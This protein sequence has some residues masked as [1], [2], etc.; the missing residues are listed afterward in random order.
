[1][2]NKYSANY[3]W[4][5]YIKTSTDLLYE[6]HPPDVGEM[7]TFFINKVI[8]NLKGSSIV[9]LIKVFVD[10]NDKEDKEPPENVENIEINQTSNCSSLKIRWNNPGNKDFKGVILARK[11]SLISWSPKDGCEY[12]PGKVKNTDIIIIYNGNKNNY[13]D[14]NIE[15]DSYYFFKIFSYDNKFNYS[16]GVQKYLKTNISMPEGEINANYD[17]EKDKFNIHF[18][19]NEYTEKIDLSYS[20]GSDNTFKTIKSYEVGLSKDFTKSISIENSLRNN[21]IC[22]IAEVINNLNQR[23]FTDK[24]CLPY[25]VP[26]SIY[27]E[28]PNPPDLREM[29]KTYNYNNIELSWKKVLDKNNYQNATYYI[30]RYSDNNLFKNYKDEKV[31]NPDETSKYS[32]VTHTINN[33]DDNKI[34]YFKVIAFNDLCEDQEDKWLANATNWSKTIYAIINLP[35]EPEFVND[36]FRPVNGEI[37]VSKTPALE[38]KVNDNDNEDIDYCVLIS[39]NKSNFE[40]LMCFHQ[41]YQNKSELDFN[42]DY[43]PL[44]PYT[45]YY[46]KVRARDRELKLKNSYKESEVFEFTTIKS[47]PDLSIT[48]IDYNPDD[49]KPDKEVLFKLTVKNIGSEKSNNKQCIKANYKKNNN[50]SPFRIY[51]GCMKEYLNVNESEIVDFTVKFQ[52]SIIDL[53]GDIYDNILISGDSEIKF[54]FLFK[55]DQDLDLSNNSLIKKINY[56]NKGKPELKY[57]FLD[58]SYGERM[59]ESSNDKFWGCP[60]CPIKISAEA[61][62][63]I[64]II[65]GTIEVQYESTEP[66][67]IFDKS[68]NKS[69]MN[70]QHDY[71][72]GNI[73]KTTIVRFIVSFKDDNNLITKKESPYFK[74]YPNNMDFKVELEQDEFVANEKI[75]YQIT[76]NHSNNIYKAEVFL[77]DEF[78]IYSGY[79]QNGITF[80]LKL[81]YTITNKYLVSPNCYLKATLI[82]E[83]NNKKEYKSKTFS[84]KPDTKLPAPFLELSQIYNKQEEIP[85]NAVRCGYGALTIQ[86]KKLLY[87]NIDNANKVHA[88]I[89][90]RCEYCVNDQ[91]GYNEDY[92]FY[93]NDY[94]YILYDPYSKEVVNEVKMIEQDYELVAFNLSDNI[95]YAIFES[96]NQELY[97]TYINRNKFVDLKILEN[98]NMPILKNAEK[99]SEFDESSS[100][101]SDPARY[102]L[103]DRTI[104][105]L[106]ISY[107]NEVDTYNFDQG[108]IGKRQEIR[109][110]KNFNIRNN[111][112]KPTTVNNK[113]KIYACD[114]PNSKLVELDT[115]SNIIKTFKIPYNIGSSGEEVQKTSIA[116]YDGNLFIFGNGRFYI[117]EN[118]VIIDKGPISFYDEYYEKNEDISSKWSQIKYTKSIITEN[119]IYLI[120]G[121]SV[122][123]ISSILMFNSSNYSFTKKIY[124]V[125]YKKIS[126]SPYCD[127]LYIG[128]D[129]VLIA[130][131]KDYAD[132]DYSGAIHKYYS[133]LNI[134]D[135]K[136]GDIAYL[137]ELP[138]KSKDYISLLKQDNNIFLIGKNE[139]LHKTEIF[140]L[141]IGNI[142]NEAKLVKN[143]SLQQ[144]NGNLYAIWNY[145]TP[146]NGSLING[147]YAYKQYRRNIIQQ[148]SPYSNDKKIF[149]NEY[150]SWITI[151]GQ[152]HVM[153]PK[154]QIFTINHNL[155]ANTEYNIGNGEYSNKFEFKYFDNSKIIGG[156]SIDRKLKLVEKDYNDIDIDCNIYEPEIAAFDSCVIAAGK[157]DNNFTV[158]KYDL[159]TR[160]YF[161]VTV[162][163]D[164][165]NKAF[166]KVDINKNKW[167]VLGWDIFVTVADFSKDVI[168]PEVK[169]IPISDEISPGNNII[170]NWTAV[171]NQDKLKYF[172]II[173]KENTIEKKKEII[174]DITINEFKY[175][176]PENSTGKISFS[177]TA[178]DIDGNH[179]KDVIEH[180]IINPVILKALQINKTQAFIGENVTF[181]W[182]ADNVKPDTIY[183]AYIQKNDGQWDELFVETENT[184]KIVS[185]DKPGS[186]KFKLV[187]ENAILIY[188]ETIAI[189]DYNIKFESFL[190][191]TSTIYS[192]ANPSIPLTWIMK[193][194][195]TL[196]D[197]CY[198]YIKTNKET[199]FKLIKEISH[200]DNNTFS[201]LYN[202]QDNISSFNWKV[203]AVYHGFEYTSN[204]INVQ[205]DELNSP[206]IKNL[207]L[208]NAYTSEPAI[209]VIFDLLPNI[210]DYIILKKS[211]D[212][213]FI[214]VNRTQ[215]GNYLDKNISYNQS[216]TYG[217]KSIKNDVI[218]SMGNIKQV[219][220]EIIPIKRINVLSEQ[221]KTFDS[222]EIVINYYPEPEQCFEY[223]EINVYSE[224]ESVAFTRTK[225]KNR[226]ITLT[227]LLYSHNYYANIYPLDFEGNR[228]T[229]TPE[230]YN[231]TTGF[232]DRVITEIPIIDIKSVTPESVLLQWKAIKNADKYIIYRRVEFNDIMI[233]QD[234]TANL[235]YADYNDIIPGI[236]YYYKLEAAKTDTASNQFSLPV[237]VLIPHNKYSIEDVIKAFQVL[238]ENSNIVYTLLDIN[239]D[240]TNDIDDVIILLNMLTTIETN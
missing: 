6:W 47:A 94:V 152:N 166:Y 230:Q 29:N 117:L 118:N 120:M 240:N 184:I 173:V 197:K 164:I 144:L 9:E 172:E 113:N 102:I 218:A 67:V 111:Y 119:G 217:I 38:W 128:N 154:S 78:I 137:G 13:S 15:P 87:V 147:S 79:N 41:D 72:L 180:E 65:Q 56:K 158:I 155:S 104:W 24:Y 142:T 44:K 239:K 3:G 205:L 8:N 63:D 146:H 125:E 192:S 115:Q 228:L 186:Y 62:D 28:F 233:Q 105:D 177:I 100:L 190:P 238:S 210:T 14:I 116:G 59:S 185:I 130:S 175:L 32:R 156:F 82:D 200:Q 98:E 202:I 71:N 34:Y 163:Y 107:D 97:Y 194:G 176:I 33:L 189:V 134:L 129:K 209:E 103:I 27:I 168:A 227:G 181:R 169:F 145:G 80:P 153:T 2:I 136:T 90:H 86:E 151:G 124:D 31:P 226:S 57:F 208:Q 179:S 215:I 237:S 174:D 58:N 219:T 178:Y 236:K 204:I 114:Y 221:Y 16:S 148:I 108:I 43:D 139:I 143:L 235:Y 167:V 48:N 161:E 5:S 220:P 64:K 12:S 132:W 198:L 75:Q 92:H 188:P 110:E 84:I 231:F 213:P 73:S 40:E 234:E 37:N 222:N 68:N 207:Y 85:Y 66:K 49:L 162:G 193:E 36:K 140:K 81:E 199:D 88:V 150:F 46:W 201:Y 214:E 45:K 159:P 183:T 74:I 39:E 60:G 21:S 53:N 203:K 157:K 106:H 83:F 123:S 212:K 223:Y 170:L 206:D 93:K 171:D 160:E 126:R 70:F 10:D 195:S 20:Y 138:V 50:E 191:Q 96:P 196:P 35:S 131:A 229:Q 30:I 18:K 52:D 133:M 54:E 141:E 182:E 127:M 51:H 121:E 95:P 42:N 61:I 216:Y 187:S 1:M 69:F 99:I 224:S 4:F 19:V 165:D 149:S 25:T 55:D 26:G 77:G 109:L 89:N 17:A 76:G 7:K 211:E 11:S 225:T 91:T 22:F 232:D 122:G 135:L 101:F 112:I 23:N